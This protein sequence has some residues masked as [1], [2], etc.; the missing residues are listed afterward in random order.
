MVQRMLVIDDEKIVLES[1]RK[2]FSSEG[3]DVTVTS[4]P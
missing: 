1:C 3:F 2:I 4:S